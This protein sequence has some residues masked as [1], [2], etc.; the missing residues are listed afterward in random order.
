MLSDLLQ[1]SVINGIHIWRWD[2]EV[3]WNPEP[4]SYK[5]YIKVHNYPLC[6]WHPQN[7]HW[8]VAG[9]GT[10]LYVDD[11]NSLGPDR[12]TLRITVKLLDPALLPPAIVINYGDRWKRCEV[13][14]VGW[15]FY[16]GIRPRRYEGP[17]EG[18]RLSD[19]MS[20][21]ESHRYNETEDI[22]NR[23]ELD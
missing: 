9:F 15:S 1:W 21:P 7:F 16:E 8:L 18:G 17:T 12:S 20:G 23:A 14:L 2:A 3:G 6:L 22:T 5:V 4:T 19:N 13:A 11:E 10:P